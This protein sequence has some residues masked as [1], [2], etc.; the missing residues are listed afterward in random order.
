MVATDYLTKWPEARPL[1]HATVESVADFIYEEI[2]CR[3]GAPTTI[4][5][6][7]GTHFKNKLIAKLCEKFK[8][9]H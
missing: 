3:H 8:I 4:I 6:N 1:P 5:S 2:I 9:N 7:Q